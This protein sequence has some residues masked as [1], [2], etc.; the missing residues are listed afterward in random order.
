MPRPLYNEIAIQINQLF[1]KVLKRLAAI[2]Q[3]TIRSDDYS[4]D[5]L[6]SFLDRMVQT[7]K[8]LFEG[9]SQNLLDAKTQ[10]ARVKLAG[11]EID[12]RMKLAQ[13]LN[14]ILQNLIES[15]QAA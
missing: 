8:S 1:R 3:A 2:A 4:A 12:G 14:E 6:H 15:K 10:E 11:L 9:G 7:F 13:Q 5:L